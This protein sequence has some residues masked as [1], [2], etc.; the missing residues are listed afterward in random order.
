MWI[1]Y[2]SRSS[3]G[4]P[5]AI[6]ARAKAFGV[7]TVFVKSSDGMAWWSQF[8]PELVSALKAAGLR[9]CAWQF[10]YGNRPATE[11][12]LGARAAQT[13][14][15]CL[16]IDAE[17]AYE[18]K[19]GQAQDYVSTLRAQ[20]GADFPLAL[21]GFPYVDY[22]PAFP[23]S[24]FLGAGGAQASLPQVYWK[25]IGVTVDQAIDHTY[26]WNTVYGRPIFPLGQLYDDP[27]PAEI[28]RFRQLAGARGAT[29]LSWWSWQSAAVRGWDAIAKP[30]APLAGPPMPPEYP[31]LK[32][33]Q[34]GDVV[35][36]AQE[37]LISGGQTVSANGV[38]TSTVEQAVRAF[39]AA[40]ALPVTGQVDA[41][42]WTALLQYHPAAPDWGRAA[43]ASTSA[44]TPN[45]PISARLAQ[46]DD[47]LR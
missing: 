36:W 30:L 7:R 42:T 11:A 2:V 9:V 44:R 26:T 16:V 38:Y 20:I 8:S 5:S 21:S 23:Y 3:A 34:R 35:V 46:R 29:G 41:P 14:A 19:Y 13:G 1:W 22:H 24:V 47:E 10:V 12:R 6:G 17:S 45:G 43:R 15:D 31:T 40:S 33:G 25:A 39:Q 37:H 18:G 4:D 28:Q 27:S 32:R